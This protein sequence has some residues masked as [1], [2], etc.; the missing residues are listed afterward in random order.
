MCMKRILSIFTTSVLVMLCAVPSY[1]QGYMATKLR[2]DSVKPYTFHGTAY[3]GAKVEQS[4]CFTVQVEGGLECMVPFKKHKLRFAGKMNF[5]TYNKF[6]NGNRGYAFI[7]GDFYQFHIDEKPKVREKNLVFFS[8]IGGAQY[9]FCRDMH[10]RI[11]TGMMAIFQPLRKHPHLCLEPGIGFLMD[12]SY[13]NALAGADRASLLNFYNQPENSAVRAYLGIRPDGYIWQQDPSIVMSVNFLGEWDRIAFNLYVMA[14]QPV[15]PTFQEDN[16]EAELP[17]V[18]QHFFNT[19]WL[20]LVTID[21]SLDIKLNK[22]LS[23]RLNCEFLWDG[24]Q[25]PGERHTVE[26]EGKQ[27]PIGAR[28][29][30]YCFTG[31]L[32]IRW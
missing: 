30:R 14:S 26:F 1:G 22:T 20:P 5:N 17:T 28:N 23:L 18:F 2:I 32:A 13:W 27:V 3:V 19:K 31:G 29:M 6:D 12:F 21:G 10:C 9:D 7:A 16:F 15:T 4:D 24:G 11:F 25:L 8:A